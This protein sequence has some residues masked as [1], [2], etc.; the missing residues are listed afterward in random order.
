MLN[1]VRAQWNSER[2]TSENSVDRINFASTATNVATLVAASL[3][4][5]ANANWDTREGTFAGATTNG[6][7]SGSLAVTIRT[8]ISVWHISPDLSVLTT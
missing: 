8:Q 7:G 6:T 3:A 2:S 1:Q 5:F 4:I